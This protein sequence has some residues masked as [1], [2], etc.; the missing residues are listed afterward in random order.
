MAKPEQIQ[1]RAFLSYSQRD[2]GVAWRVHKTLETFRIDPDLAGRESLHLK[3]I[4]MP[5]RL[6]IR[7]R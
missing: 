4:G 2:T 6:V 1:Y 3:N 5:S 7:G